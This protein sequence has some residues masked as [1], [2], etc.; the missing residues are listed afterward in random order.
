LKLENKREKGGK[1]TVKNNEEPKIIEFNGMADSL[2]RLS[3]LTN[4]LNALRFQILQS[5]GS[6]QKGFLIEYSS[7]LE[8]YYLE[9]IG[10]LDI[11]EMADI[12]DNCLKPIRVLTEMFS[13]NRTLI[14]NK[15]SPAE[16]TLRLCAKKHGFITRNIVKDSYQ[17][18]S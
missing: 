3:D 12:E 16:K 7:T 4:L 13:L 1:N 15:I 18:M 2:K 6:K 9:I 17:T 11:E 8:S 14:L 10:E 5:N